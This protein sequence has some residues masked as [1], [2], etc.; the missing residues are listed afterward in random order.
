MAVQVTCRCGKRFAAKDRMAGQSLPCPACGELLVIPA[1]VRA[2]G[3]AED[4]PELAASQTFSHHVL[5]PT[6]KPFPWEKV[7]P[8]V[9]GGVLAGVLSTMIVLALLG[10]RWLNN[11]QLFGSPDEAAARARGV[12]QAPAQDPATSDPVDPGK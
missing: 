1:P 4:L 9:L 3:P 6:P 12:R 8:W 11:S 5:P 2:I 10:I 7:M